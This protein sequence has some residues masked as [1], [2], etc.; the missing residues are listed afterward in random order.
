MVEILTDGRGDSGN[1]VSLSSSFSLYPF[2]FFFFPRSISLFAAYY[3]S[4][5]RHVQW[6]PL[7]PRLSLSLSLS[8]SYLDTISS[9]FSLVDST[10]TLS[11]S[12]PVLLGNPPFVPFSPTPSQSPYLYASPSLGSTPIYVCM[13][14]LLFPRQGTSMQ[15]CVRNGGGITIGDCARRISFTIVTIRGEDRKTAPHVLDTHF[16]LE[17]R[18]GSCNCFVPRPSKFYR[19]PRF[20]KRLLD[21]IASPRLA[22]AFSRF[23]LSLSFSLFL[24]LS[25][26][27]NGRDPTFLCLREAR[28]RL[29]AL[30][31][32]AP[33]SDL[34]NFTRGREKKICLE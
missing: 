10:L 16:T 22:A 19:D 5:R 14:P 18:A 21:R 17:R 23:S 15:P 1:S 27:V 28:R 3:L 11:F 9:S 26:S 29:K 4:F 6:N 2:L 34:E 24:S 7:F 13:Y 32:I 33:A 8:L 30:S 12:Q 31:L 20:R 25:V